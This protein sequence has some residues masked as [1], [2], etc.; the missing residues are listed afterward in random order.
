MSLTY[1]TRVLP[2]FINFSLFSGFTYSPKYT[3]SISS[4]RATLFNNPLTASK[5]WLYSSNLSFILGY[6]L[7]LTFSKSLSN[8]SFLSDTTL[9]IFFLIISS[10]FF[11]SANFLSTILIIA[12]ILSFLSIGISFILCLVKIIISLA[13]KDNLVPINLCNLISFSL[14]SL[15]I[16]SAI[17]LAISLSFILLPI[18]K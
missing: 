13:K 1:L 2:G 7:F 8:S 6:H 12:F 18:N 15:F 5:F 17:N 11:N 16:I 9:I 14:G 4:A 10:V 3:N